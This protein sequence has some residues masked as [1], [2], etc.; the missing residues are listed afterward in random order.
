VWWPKG[1]QRKCPEQ[2]VSKTSTDEEEAKPSG[3][4]MKKLFQTEID[5]EELLEKEHQE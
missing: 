5:P 4:E 3:S 1:G 2:P